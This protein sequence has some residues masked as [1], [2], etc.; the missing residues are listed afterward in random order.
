MTT[1]E[2]EADV[3]HGVIEIPAM[4]RDQMPASVHVLVTLTPRPVPSGLLAHLLE[5][6][7][8]DPAFVPLTREDIYAERMHRAE[9]RTHD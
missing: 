4:Y 5:H 7:I 6:P 3:R 1:I 2:F 9:N 8:D